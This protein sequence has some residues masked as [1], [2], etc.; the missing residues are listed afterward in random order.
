[1]SVP[2]LKIAGIEI[3]MH[4]FPARQTYRDLGGLAFHRMANG[5]AISQQHWRKLGIGISG[6]G[7]A[8]PALLGVDWSAPVVVSCI[9]PRSVASA[10]INATLPAARRSDAAPYAMA[11]VSG[12][13][14][15]TPMSL[16]GAAATATAVSGA[17]GYRFFYYPELTCYAL[18]GVEES[19]DAVSASFSWSIDAEEA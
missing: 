14:V 15:P 3:S 10:T 19:M 5:A 1:M 12:K 11:L 13:L 4:E 9:A 7:W 2:T 8:P 18:N 16:V 6:D 17:S